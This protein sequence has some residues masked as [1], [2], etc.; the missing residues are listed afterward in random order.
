MAQV[1]AVAG[2]DQ[3]SPGMNYSFF[4]PRQIV[5]GWG[6]RQELGRLVTAIGQRVFLV[7]GSRTLERAGVI[8]ELI[9]QLD[10]ARLTTLG[11]PVASREPEVRDVDELV[12][13]LRSFR[14]ASG[15]VVVAV[16]GGATLDLAKAAAALATQS[17]EAS[18]HDYLE[19][20]GRGLTLVEAPL[21]LVAVP[22]TA[23]TGSEATKNAVISSDSG[24]AAP[25]KKSLRSDQMVPR[26]V[27]VDP[28]F[29]VSL[30]PE[31]TAST[32]MDAITQLIESYISRRA[33]PIPQ[34][35][36][37]Q[38]L[39]LA[40]PALPNAMAD[41]GCRKAREA[42]SHAALL[43]GMALA[44]SGL[45]L[46]HGVAAALGVLCQAPHG[47]ACALMLPTALRVNEQVSQRELASLEALFAPGCDDSARGA[48][49]FIERIENLCRSVGIPSRLRDVGVTPNQIPE[50]VRGSRGNSMSGNPRDVSDDELK[51]LLEAL[52]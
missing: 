43:S 17:V 6:R 42:L 26:L 28:E 31:T 4:S 7:S 46:A 2:Q 47:L 29:T 16:G 35:L 21:P 37:V 11:F 38:G 9:R 30:R 49:D 32:G 51:Q 3:Y 15:D 14:P 5:F 45:G 20:V 18:V 33:A 12:A 36:C 8:D 52:W 39:Q 48:R 40:I 44:N 10:L 22:T 25:F 50:L 41:G 34:A 24:A 1:V 19:G 27:L 13:G 23:G